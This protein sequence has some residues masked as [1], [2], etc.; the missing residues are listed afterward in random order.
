MPELRK[1]AEA[2]V[3]S[4]HT[5]MDLV[6]LLSCW[7]KYRMSA[8]AKETLT[9]PDE[10]TDKLRPRNQTP[11]ISIDVEYSADNAFASNFAVE[12]IASNECLV[13]L[14]YKCHN[15]FDTIPSPPQ[16]VSCENSCFVLR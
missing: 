2:Y 15:R 1:A 7:A 16:H 14:L 13:R 8:K 10:E 9:S 12:S 5:M 11:C 6:E 3:W 4:K